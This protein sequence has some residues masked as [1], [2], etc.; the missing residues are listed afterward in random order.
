MWCPKKKII[1]KKSAINLN[2]FKWLISAVHKQWSELKYLRVSNH[3]RFYFLWFHSN[4]TAYARCPI[5][6][7]HTVSALHHTLLV[8]E[9]SQSHV[10]KNMAA[11]MKSL[12]KQHRSVYTIWPDVSPISFIVWC[13]AIGLHG[14]NAL[15]SVRLS[16]CLS[17][18][19][20]VCALLAEPCSKGQLPSSSEQRMAVTSP[21]NVFVS[22]IR[23][24]LCIISWMRSI[25]FYAR[26]Y[27]NA[28]WIM[29]HL[30]KDKFHYQEH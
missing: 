7:H 5:A 8:Y 11:R 20:F 2:V 29:P 12:V 3:M 22:V 17:V 9:G 6:G 19:Q 24:L 4:C 14:D 18:R 26:A 15:G 28:F 30:G 21:M 16:A 1:R 10:I 27:C 23:G 13:C 25:C